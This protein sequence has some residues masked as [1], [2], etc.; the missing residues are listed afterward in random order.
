MSGADA[1][2][3]PVPRS[4]LRCPELRRMWCRRS[5]RRHNRHQL[6]LPNSTAPRSVTIL[7]FNPAPIRRLPVTK[8]VPQ[9]N[10]KRRKATAPTAS[11]TTPATRV[12]LINGLDDLS[13]ATIVGISNG[14]QFSYT[15]NIDLMGDLGH[16]N[17]SV[18][19]L[20]LGCLREAPIKMAMPA[21]I[22]NCIADPDS[23]G[24][25]LDRASELL[26]QARVPVLNRPQNVRKTTRDNIYRLLHNTPGLVVPRTVRLAPRRLS[27][28][29]AAMADGDIGMPFLIRPAGQHGGAG[30]LRVDSESDLGQLERF[31]FDGRGYYL[32]EF[33]DFRSPDGLYRKYRLIML[34]GRV[35][36]RHLIASD[37]WNIHSRSRST[38]MQNNLE[39]IAQ[40]QA[41]LDHPERHFKESVQQALAQIRRELELDYFGVDC[42]LNADGD[43][44][45]FEI[46]ACVNVIQ[47]HQAPFGYLNAA[48]ERIRTGVIEM[49][50]RRDRNRS[51]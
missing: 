6:A 49:V 22:F 39:L 46:N 1:A 24:R 25:S 23:H 41:F 16:P 35:Y 32:T 13:N 12:L 19:Q 28:I 42:G 26:E 34:D 4:S 2:L 15:G 43:L 31:A 5:R 14:V 3:S 48:V 18:S 17:L 11:R 30:L 29:R 37:H 40:E 20:L 44:V 10:P 27:D 9:N 45:V 21:V 33:V 38:V 8:H 50:L 7:Y 36:P 47:R 51:A